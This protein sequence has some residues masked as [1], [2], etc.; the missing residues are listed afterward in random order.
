MLENSAK[1]WARN[2]VQHRAFARGLFN[3]QYEGHKDRKTEGRREGEE[4]DR[5]RD[6]APHF[7]FPSSGS[8]GSQ[9]RSKE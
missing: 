9:G 8:R 5:D 7:N 1:L 2:T 6:M 3:P 4:R